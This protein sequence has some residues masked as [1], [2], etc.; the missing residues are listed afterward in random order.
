MKVVIFFRRILFL[1]FSLS[2]SLGAWEVSRKEAES[3]GKR[4]YWN[5]CSGNPDKLIW[6]NAGENFASLGIG[7]F[8]WYPK[9]V[10]GPFE[11]MFP[12]LISFLKDNG[13]EIPSW[14]T[15]CDGCPWKTKEE[16]LEKK[17]EGKKKELQAFL[18]QTI[19]WQAA[20]IAERFKQDLP[21]ILAD[22]SEEKKAVIE[23]LGTPQGKYALLDYMNFKGK[24]I[25]ET[26]RYQGKGW[27][28]KQVLEAMPKKTE[29]PLG[30]FA[31][32]AKTLLKQRVESAPPERH[33]ERW[34]PG[35]LKRVDSYLK[36]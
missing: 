19:S 17:Q 34:L 9:G 25:L 13:V 27:G 28:L 11:E 24:G 10:Q 21:Q 32:A 33:E 6:W 4:I 14:L 12:S 29:D 30:C 7:H 36:S 8:I 22:L 1:C 5:E 23:K 31:E 2:I 26:E 3:I 18:F 35:W 15:Q 20:F 16:F